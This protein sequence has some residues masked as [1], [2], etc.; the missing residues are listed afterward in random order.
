[1]YIKCRTI[2]VT[3]KYYNRLKY[4]ELYTAIVFY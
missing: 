1:M 2:I 3:V 4:S